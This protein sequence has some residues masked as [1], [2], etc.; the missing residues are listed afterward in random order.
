MVDLVAV[1]SLGALSPHTIDEA[2]FHL[3]LL[4]NV[5]H[6]KASDPEILAES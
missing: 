6:L 4:V 5:V 2:L 3:F 1:L